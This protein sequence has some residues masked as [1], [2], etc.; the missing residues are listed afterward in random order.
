MLF[1]AVLWI[2]P[3]SSIFTILQST[4]TVLFAFELMINASILEGVQLDLSFTFL[5]FF[6]MLNKNESEKK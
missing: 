1:K 6:Q 2:V 5:A 3:G 4:F